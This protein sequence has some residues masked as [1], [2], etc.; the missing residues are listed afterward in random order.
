MYRRS[1]EGQGPK[2]LDYT[3]YPFREGLLMRQKN[4]RRRQHPYHPHAM[5]GRTFSVPVKSLT[6]SIQG[7]K[8]FSLYHPL[9]LEGFPIG[10]ECLTGRWQSKVDH[11]VRFLAESGEL[12]RRKRI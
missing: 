12:L 9:T 1:L 10:S 8:G 11:L 3:F 2:R 7:R 5:I 4:L 6:V